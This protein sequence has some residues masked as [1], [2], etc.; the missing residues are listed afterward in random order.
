[1]MSITKGPWTFG[2]VDYLGDGP[3]FKEVPFDYDAEGYSN[4]PYIFGANGEIVAG[5]DEYHTLGG[6]DD[7]RLMCA[8][9]DLLE[10]LQALLE[11]LELDGEAKAW[12]PKEQD[13]ARKAIAKALA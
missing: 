5:C 4:N 13:D 2:V 12:F 3:D 8:A 10:A 7:A 9:P 1:M 6:A 11:R